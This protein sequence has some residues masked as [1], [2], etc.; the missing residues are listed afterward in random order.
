MEAWA[1]FL[2]SIYGKY[3]SS[4]CMLGLCTPMHHTRWWSVHVHVRSRIWHTDLHVHSCKLVGEAHL[5]LAHPMSNACAMLGHTRYGP[6]DDA[7]VTL[8]S[9]SV[10]CVVY[11]GVSKRS[12]SRHQGLMQ[13]KVWKSS[14]RTIALHCITCTG[15]PYNRACALEVAS[16]S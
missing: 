5:H 8:R 9:H 10:S 2:I 11:L 3:P 15:P 1:S 7:R 13:G 12:N 14:G 6:I 16:G 4:P